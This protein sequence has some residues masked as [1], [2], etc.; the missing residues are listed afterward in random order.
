MVQDFKAGNVK[1]HTDAWR[2]IGAPPLIIDWVSNGVQLLFETQPERFFEP[3]HRL[4]KKETYFV[5]QEIKT[6]VSQGALVQCEEPYCVSPITCVPKKQSYRLIT[7]LRRFNS[8]CTKASFQNEDIQ[9]F[10]DQLKP[11][12]H[13][14]KVDIKSGYFNIYVHKH[15][16]KY[17]C[18]AWR[19]ITYAW[20]V[21][22]FG[23]TLSPFFFCK[24]LRPVVAYL[25][26]LGLRLSLYVDDF[27]LAT[28][29]ELFT[30]H[31]QILLQTLEDLGLQVNW[32]KSCLSPK[33][34]LI[35]IGYE[36][37]TTNSDGKVWV[38]IPKVRIRKA[39]RDIRRTLAKGLTSARGLARIAGQLIA[40]SKAVIPAKLLLRNMYRL[41][42]S[43]ESWRDNL[44]IDSGTRRD[45]VWWLAALDSWN[46][47]ALVRQAIEGQIITDASQEAWGSVY[48]NQEAHGQWNTRLQY[49]HS[50]YRELMAILLSLE[51]F[52]PQVQGK[53]IQVLTDNV[54]AAAYINFQGG[55]NAELSQLATAV[56]STA[57]KYNITIC[58][59][60]L[61]G[62]CNQHAD[63]LS[64]IVGL[65][66]W[67][68]HPHLF[69]FLDLTFGPHTI[70]RF[71]SMLNTHLSR[72]NS[73][74]WDPYTEGVDALAQTNWASENNFVNAPFRMIPQV[75][76]VIIAQKAV[77]TVIAP[78]WRGQAWQKTLI[79]LSVAPPIRLP[80]IQR[81]FVPMKGIL[82]EPLRNHRWKIYAWRIFGGKD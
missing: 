58:G 45:L 55:Q 31:S 66:E 27:A 76:N 53:C 69:N 20:T 40:M 15:F 16:Q 70:D 56:W 9:T 48:E 43:R 80:N 13:L 29:P 38:R 33:T 50:N 18:I 39:K 7:D 37:N 6:L 77:A 81:A 5:D 19:G 57:L 3:N 74:F 54:T 75:L 23:L 47:R 59:K 79:D 61:A 2:R 63:R 8:S 34:E 78:A 1:N 44:R 42:R 32:E 24:I 21:L 52:G 25:R 22:P 11:K 67:K 41:L 51:T 36:I 64:R 17:L 65:Y 26:S 10:F 14:A 30:K 28:T 60:Y 4:S 72:Y 12:D 71:S 49:K 46:G 35:Y 82:P 62:K 73:Q 68:L